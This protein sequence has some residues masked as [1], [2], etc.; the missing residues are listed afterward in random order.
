MGDFPALIISTLACVV[1]TEGIRPDEA[2][3]ARATAENIAMAAA[4]CPSY[5]AARRA[6]EVLRAK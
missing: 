6:D 2:M 1:L 3:L 4:D 5:E